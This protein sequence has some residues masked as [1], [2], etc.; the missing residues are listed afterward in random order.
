MKAIAVVAPFAWAIIHGRK[1][2][3]NRSTHTTYRGRVLIYVSKSFNDDQVKSV[4]RKLDPDI[5]PNFPS[6]E[7]LQGLC[8]HLI[9]SV[10]IVGS[11]ETSKSKWYYPDNKAWMLR[12]PKSIRPVPYSPLKGA[13]GWHN[14]DD[15]LI[16]KEHLR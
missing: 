13:V 14:V 6:I 9:G 8:G 11:S 15:Q 16:P 2:V 10:E 5:R 4:S 1:D 3:E 7:G 12:N